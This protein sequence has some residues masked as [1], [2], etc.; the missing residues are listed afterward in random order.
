MLS[1]S[2]E[3]RRVGHIRVF[4]WIITRL[5]QTVYI[6][7]FR[8][9]E[10]S[11]IQKL[12][13]PMP[14]CRKCGRRLAEY[15]EA[16]TECGTST[17]A[18]I[19]KIKKATAIRIVKAVAP[20][21]KVAKANI[22][23][24]TIISVKVIAPKTADKANFSTKTVTPAKPIIKA[25]QIAL[26]KP[27]TPAVVYPPHEIIKSNI[28]LKEDYLANPQDY[29]TQTFSFNL[30]CPNEHFWAAGKTLPTSTGKALCPQCGERLRK[31]KRKK[32]RRQHRF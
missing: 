27:V 13:E 8:G 4:G 12:S 31:P 3:S 32:V 7:K 28:S 14:F 9:V 2:Y 19:I 15:S 1:D 29:E 21:A 16:C 11:W 23:A 25:K 20:P 5:Q 10:S 26:T 30:Q 17:T 18:P 24:K 6:L 22:P